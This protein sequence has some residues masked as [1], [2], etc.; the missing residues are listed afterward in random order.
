MIHSSCIKKNYFK[1]HLE[2]SVW[3]LEQF[4]LLIF[5]TDL[6]N[7]V[8]HIAND[9]ELVNCWQKYSV[10]LYQYESNRMYCTLLTHS[11]LAGS[12]L[13]IVYQGRLSNISL[14]SHILW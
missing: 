12:A 11:F 3:S 7:K 10:N 6:I 13:V 1:Q 4:Y 8:K 2:Y 14:L 5:I 9:F